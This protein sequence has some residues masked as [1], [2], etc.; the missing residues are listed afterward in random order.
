MRY[1]LQLP[2][3][4][5]FSSL[6]INELQRQF[7]LLIHMSSYRYINN[8]KEINVSIS[9][10]QAAVSIKAKLHESFLCVVAV[11]HSS[12]S[13]FKAAKYSL[14]Y[15]HHHHCQFLGRL[16]LTTTWHDSSTARAVEQKQQQLLYPS[17]KSSTGQLWVHSRR[18]TEGDTG[19]NCQNATEYYK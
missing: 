6:Y 3:S 8:N 10:S 16:S 14:P 2:C 13:S 15:H 18:F 1:I 11:L 7:C 5:Q 17:S 4:P 9:F 19:Q 12:S